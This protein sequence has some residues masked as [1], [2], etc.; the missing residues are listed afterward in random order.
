LIF[1][2]LIAVDF[3]RLFFSH[4]QITNAAREGANYGITRP[5]DTSGIYARAAQEANVQTQQNGSAGAISVTTTCSPDSCNDARTNA[6]QNVVTVTVSR[7]FALLTPLIG[8]IF[9]NLS[10]TATASSV[11]LGEA[12]IPVTPPPCVSVPNV[13]G[14]SPAAANSAIIGVGLVPSGEDKPP[15]GGATV[16]SQN[17]AA[18]ACVVASATVVHFE[19]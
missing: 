17:P 4:I 14:L 1:V 18:G 16:V 12:G 3:G 19:Y 6:N 9:S 2:L 13:V 8:N 11:A 10:V 7:T 15:S 5:D